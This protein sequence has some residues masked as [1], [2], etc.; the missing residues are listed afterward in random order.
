[1]MWLLNCPLC[2]IASEQLHRDIQYLNDLYAEIK[3]CAQK[4]EIPK[5]F[6]IK[7]PFNSKIKDMAV[8]IKV[9]SSNTHT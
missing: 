4:E 7:F 3:K 6:V 8:L 9:N 1:M 2:E 5:F